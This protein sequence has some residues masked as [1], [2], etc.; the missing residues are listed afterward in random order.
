METPVVAAEE[1]RAQ[2]KEDADGTQCVELG[3]K[4]GGLQVDQRE[5]DQD[6]EQRHRGEL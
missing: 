2:D 6:Q 5:Q 3:E 4:G 1:D